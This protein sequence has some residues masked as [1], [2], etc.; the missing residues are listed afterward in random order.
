MQK[1]LGAEEYVMVEK[2]LE[3]DPIFRRLV[4][5]DWVDDTRTTK[6]FIEVTAKGLKV[7]W[8]IGTQI[9]VA[10]SPQDDRWT[11]NPST[12]FWYKVDFLNDEIEKPII[13]Q[14]LPDEDDFQAIIQDESKKHIA[15]KLIYHFDLIVQNK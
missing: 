4:L 1:K 12:L 13:R 11:T 9:T 6:D 10:L 3:T 7:F 8:L 14:Y 15:E 5:S 2:F